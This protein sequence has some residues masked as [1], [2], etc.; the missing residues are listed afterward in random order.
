MTSG[1]MAT[2]SYGQKLVKN[3]IS[4][5]Y[6]TDEESDSYRECRKRTTR[7]VREFIWC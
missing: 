4:D 7:A 6:N 5:I 1:N 2:K 3:S